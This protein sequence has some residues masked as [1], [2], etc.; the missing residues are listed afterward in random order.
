MLPSG[1]GS[2]RK[3]KVSEI[4]DNEM[5]AIKAVFID[6][7]CAVKDL[8]EESFEILPPDYP[9]KTH[10][11]VTPY[12]LQLSTVVFARFQGLPFRRKNKLNEFLKQANNSAKVVKFTTDINL[13]DAP[14][15]SLAFM[16]SVKLVTGAIGGN[17]AAD[18]LRNL[19]MLWLQDIAELIAAPAPFGCGP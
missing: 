11:F 3:S 14:A 13:P 6:A 8:S 5:M 16:A 12:Y 18:A 17:Y 19:L 1:G 9:V 15:S 4:S 7:G 10:V 2:R